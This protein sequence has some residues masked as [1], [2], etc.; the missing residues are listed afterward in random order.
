MEYVPV[1][2]QR[3]QVRSPAESADDV[4]RL[5][6]H[7]IIAGYG[8]TGQE[9]GRSLDECGVP[10]VVVD[11]NPENIRGA[12]ERGEP[13]YFGDVTSGEVL[14]SLGLSRARELVLAI[15]DIGATVHAI[16]AARRI[17]PT[18]PIFVR[19]SYAAD[20]DRVVKAGATEVVAAELEVSVV[21]TQ[22]ILERCHVEDGWV[23]PNLERI[24]DRREDE[25]R[26]DT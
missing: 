20:V 4:H 19:V 22:R 9:L 21:V 7:V 8:I 23:A 1:L 5:K 2:T 3:L 17:E 6:D 25:I 16:H 18:V 10:H 15:N 13:A 12:L 14:E 26:S 24:R 11:I